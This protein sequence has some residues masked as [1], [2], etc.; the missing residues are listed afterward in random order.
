MWGRITG[1]SDASARD[2]DEP[3]RRKRSDSSTMRRSKGAE[4][5]VSATSTR[6]PSGRERDRDS[7]SK[8]PESVADSYASFATAREDDNMRDNADLYNDPRDDGRRRRSD[9]DE[10]STYSRKERSRSRERGQWQRKSSTNKSKEKSKDAEKEK[11]TKKKT[12]SEAG[13]SRSE[14][15]GSRALAL[16][17]SPRRGSRAMAGQNE[18]EYFPPQSQYQAS[19]AQNPQYMMSGGLPAGSMSSHVQD[20]F[21]GQN[22]AQFAAPFV[23]HAPVHTG[24]FGEAADYY[25]DQ[26]QSVHQQPGV[27]PDAPS[28]L[29][30]LDT[31]HLMSASSQ[32]NPVA[33][34]GNGAAAD[35]YGPSNTDTKTSKPPRPSSMPGAFTDDEP[36]PPKPPRP[37]SKPNK[38]SKIGSATTMAGAAGL[39]YATGY[40]SSHPQQTQH[41]QHTT[42]YTNGH[43]VPGASASA[44][45]QGDNASF[46]TTED[47]QLPNYYE[48]VAEKPPAKPPRP[49]K[50]E[51]DSHGSS[52]SGQL[53]A[54]AAG[55]AAYG[56]AHNHSH[57][58]DHSQYPHNQSHHHSMPAGFPSDPYGHAPNQFM[59]G[60][61][62]QRHETQSPVTKLAD[63]WNN[64]EDIRKMEEYTEYIG[65]CRGCFDPR[66]SVMDAPRKH[67]YGPGRKRSGELRAS[68][69]PEKHSR[70]G[71]SEKASRLSLSGDEKRPKRKN[72]S[73]GTG[74][75]AAGLGTV[76]LAQAGK[77]LFGRQKDFDD[78]YSIKSGRYTRN[79]QSRSRSG[80]SGS[81]HKHYS[82][83]RSDIRRRSPSW[84]RMSVGVTGSR[85][86]RQNLRH[87]SRSKSRSKSRDRKSGILGSAFGV[88]IAASAIGASSRRKHHS[89]SRSGSTS[90]RRQVI[91]HRRDSSSN[92]RRRTKT[93]RMS[94]KSSR[95]SVTSGSLVDV[96]NANSS[97]GGFLSGFFSAPPPKVKR[98]KSRSKSKK[99]KAGFFNFGNAS[100][101]SSDA[102]IAFGTG[103]VQPKKRLS[104]KS[105][106]EK[107][108]ATLLALGGTAAAIAATNAARNKG[109]HGSQVVAV[110]ENRHPRL[111]NDRRRRSVASSGYDGHDHDHHDAD[112]WED[113]PDEGMSDS[114]SSN[115]GLAF[116]DWKGKSTE[117]LV[118]NGSGTNKW[119]WRWGSK[120]KKRSSSENLYNDG[121]NSPFVGPAAAG[122]VAGAAIGAGIGRRDSSASSV[123]TLH[124]V[125]PVQSN[126][127]T[128]FDARRNPSS[129][130]P[131]PKP[132]V[133]NRPG[134]VAIQH[135]Q[136]IHQVPGT[137]YTQA[138]IQPSLVATSG[139]PVFPQAPPYSAAY[140]DQH[141]SGYADSSITPPRVRRSNSSPMQSS[142][143]KNASIAVAAAGVGAAAYAAGQSLN[144]PLSS[145]SN[146]RFDLTREQESKSNRQLR[147]EREREEE[148]QR[149]R[150]AEEERRSNELMRQQEEA[151]KYLEA[152]KLAK[153]Q[154]EARQRERA[155]EDRR[156][157]EARE[158]EV[159]NRREHEIREESQ[160]RITLE[161]QDSYRRI[162]LEAQEEQ[163]RR[164][165]REAERRE[166]E[167]QAELD[168]EEE[169]M[170]RERREAERREA[171]QQAELDRE[172]GRKRSE[173][174]D[175][176]R[177]E[178][179]RKDVERRREEE[180]RQDMMRRRALQ[181]LQGTPDRYES[182]HEL[183]RLEEQ[184]TGTS[185][186]SDVRRKERELEDRERDIVQPD[187]FKS[188]AAAAAVA[189]T[190]AMI[191]NAAI[192]SSKRD[193]REKRRS[194]TIEPQA[195][196]IEPSPIVQDYADDEIFN[197]QMFKSRKTKQVPEPART[198]EVFQEWEDKYQE[199]PVSQADF[200]APKELLNQEPV[201]HAIDPN[202]GATDLH[203]Y[204]AHEE[205]DF[206]AP[207]NPPYPPPYSFTASK[208]GQ[209]APSPPTWTVPSL[210][211]IQAT[212]PSSVRG[213]SAPP[214]PAVEP[215]P[216]VKK[217]DSDQPNPNSRGSRVSWGENQF[218]TFQVQTPV[219]TPDSYSEQFISDKDLQ[220]QTKQSRNEIIVESD[221]PKSGSKITSY[222]HEPE[223]AA[224]TQYVPDQEEDSYAGT[225]AKKSSKKDKKKAKGAAVATAAA[226]TT[227]AL[228]SRDK[229]FNMYKFDNSSTLTNPFA[230][231]YAASEVGSIYPSASHMSQTPSSEPFPALDP[232]P[233]TSKGFVEGD[234][235][236]EPSHMHIPGGF[237]DEVVSEPETAV[238]TRSVAPDND[239]K[240]KKSRYTDDDFVNQDLPKAV[241]YLPEPEPVAVREHEKPAEDDWAVSATPSKKDKKKKKK[242]QS[243]SE[244]PSAQE[245]PRSFEPEPTRGPE[246]I[247]EP[248]VPM[249]DEPISAKS[250]KKDKKKK[251]SQSASE[252][253][254]PDDVPTTTELV[255][256][257]ESIKELPQE[258]E[259][260]V[261]DEWASS[262]PLSKKDKKKRTKK[263]ESTDSWERSS[264]SGTSVVERDIRDIEPS[265]KAYSPPNT[266]NEGGIDTTTS[267]AEASSSNTPSYK[268]YSPPKASHEGGIHTSTSRS[269]GSSS[270]T[271]AAAMVG[272]FAG[273]VAASMQQ[274][275]DR[276]ASDLHQAQESLESADQRIKSDSASNGTGYDH[277]SERRVSIPSTAFDD[278]FGN[279]K[280][281]KK[282]KRQSGRYSPSVGSPLRAEWQYED[283][284]SAKS[285]PNVPKGE[286]LN[287]DG[288]A[289]I[290]L[291]Y[292]EVTS[293]P[294]QGIQDSGYYAPDDQTNHDAIEPT[295][296][297]AADREPE[298]IYS[299]GSDDRKKSKDRS[300]KDDKYDDRDTRYGVTDSKYDDE[301]DR[302]ERHRRRREHSGSADRGYALD[303][304]ESS[305]RH[306]RRRGTA[307]ADD[308]WDDSKSAISEARSEGGGERRRKHKKRDSERTGSPEYGEH[309]ARSEHRTRSPAAS[310]LGDEREHK[311]SRRKSR[312]DGSVDSTS[313][314]RKSR[315]DGSADSTSSRR[316][317]RRDG[318]A[319]SASI[320]SS[321]R[322][323]DEK[324]PRKESR[325][326]RGTSTESHKEKRSS[327][328]F[329][330][331][332][333]SKE[334]LAEPSS[335]SSRSR[336]D[337]GDGE[338]KHRRRKS[339]RGSTYGSDD[340][341]VRST[342]SSSSSRHKRKSKTDGYEDEGSKV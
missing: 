21:P 178:T 288:K 277:D 92:E 31:P 186:A 208:D 334:S 227:A 232:L 12:R 294:S 340:D 111:G 338:R 67:H 163:I 151:R 76:G 114:S 161:R 105:S 96:S 9:D 88:G 203:I 119:G 316:K 324:S 235:T 1:K 46:V 85:K 160:R 214:S 17:E 189:G 154:V 124:S 128:S 172:T 98:Q 246:L 15:G 95:S 308:D 158:T 309:R 217:Q 50:H 261:E 175:A 108:N 196:T 218:R 228:M 252:N 239:K 287:D 70:Y 126:D 282:T 104:K 247:R 122:A 237:E 179:E 33:D 241:E 137:M 167:R 275:Q 317:S 230:D 213:M 20:Q 313:S 182:D 231:K 278:E 8:A 90:P 14:A 236:A 79:R 310:E 337:E 234:F 244:D 73:N 146:V 125:Y 112:G 216:E 136:P 256:E 326:T 149:R 51:K 25:G 264:E 133:T 41:M 130:F 297:D 45:Y 47:S 132:L 272:G 3:E 57:D 64:H 6:R 116:G 204:Q 28:V 48:A 289:P 134:V 221:S 191:T 224:S 315:R 36:S 40:S 110:R 142:F 285:A 26:G 169:Q 143:K 75:L 219:Q 240:G 34:T 139:L 165:R 223:V 200:F 325:R 339:D 80:S 153:L 100:S 58:H 301:L 250:S 321:S 330:L 295:K 192:S 336:E 84:D 303:D 314:R 281:P 195:K 299:P 300:P 269:E 16:V 74:W 44:Y 162:A 129:S 284:V 220:N 155:E 43:S 198:S 177:R 305:R 276:L 56:L 145:T 255:P 259:T 183:R 144:R 254:L 18:E 81:D 201:T 242:S 298:E 307:E 306:H 102:N 27:R 327:G 274:D 212:P 123:P 59:S 103:Y 238:E 140:P 65:V 320:I 323:D 263:R 267:R 302:E 2:R 273:I 342:V 210:N 180:I 332:S 319:D 115:S 49:G 68:G 304:G 77:A 71:L 226:V 32:A 190:A 258:P 62:A 257:P 38:P 42:S 82:Y 37:S 225:M 181:D 215:Q 4:S 157:R 99:R 329:G 260:P 341:D 131:T 328:L 222:R 29:M 280:T 120:G 135:P 109:R 249:Q 293:P 83:G 193:K 296:R 39:G 72:S 174:R 53:A 141:Q 262:P 164:E 171:E 101:S 311:S 60:G 113:L 312:R 166:S 66:S 159:R 106:E 69:I 176:E 168:R 63:W 187:T 335:K 147:E 290:D 121:A 127:P 93:S 205:P 292:S 19:P 150:R 248:E 333:K 52:H 185:V 170:R 97:Q 94:R 243:V 283:Y 86:G 55:L 229:E 156:A 331:F 322:Y 209:G 268:A 202:E 138:P 78:T 207:K 206:G 118:S 91:H 54:G 194:K 7:R 233:S 188:T 279:F 13:G 35:F 197:P 253:M 211:L 24:S 245:S 152:D 61:M 107:F 318:S 23:P 30:P 22:P 11:S 173:R 89:H 5:I 270:N 266:S 87:N 199:T 184:P 117:S 286:A 10:M 291:G 265:Y 271:A 251:K 148:E